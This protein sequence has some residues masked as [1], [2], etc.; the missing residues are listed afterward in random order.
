MF[1]FGLVFHLKNSV[2]R[3]QNE[4]WRDENALFNWTREE[5]EIY[6]HVRDAKE[7]YQSYTGVVPDAREYVCITLHFLDS[8]KRMETVKKALLVANV[9]ILKCR[10]LQKHLEHMLPGLCIV[11]RCTTLQLPLC[12]EETY[13]L[14][15]TMHPLEEG[16]KP[17]AD[18]SHVERA[19][20]KAYLERFLE[21]DVDR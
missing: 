7:I 21:K 4:S 16:K 8:Q 19:E 3:L 5:Q 9:D 18:L 12:Q 14:I 17:V 13:D 6:S 1:Y 10:E 15:I 20:W 11:E 2:Y